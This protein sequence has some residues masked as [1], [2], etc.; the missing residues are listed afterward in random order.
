[1]DLKTLYSPEFIF[2]NSSIDKADI[3]DY[4][5]ILINLCNQLDLKNRLEDDN[6]RTT[7][8]KI[9]N[10]DPSNYTDWLRL[11]IVA[12]YLFL[13]HNW[14]GPAISFD[15]NIDWLVNNKNEEA[16]RELT[17]GDQCNDN[18]EYLELLYLSKIIF[19]NQKLQQ[20]LPTSL[21]WAIRSNYVHQ[22]ILDEES[23]VL[24]N[25]TELLIDKMSKL[26]DW[27]ND[28]YKSFETLFYIEALQFTLLYRRINDSEK[29][30]KQAQTIAKLTLELGG[31]QGK[32]TKYQEE[33]KPQLF[34]DIKT[35][36]EIFP[37]EVC[38][39]LPHS[40]H[41][42]DDL[43]LD[44]V[45]FSEEI[46][47]VELGSIEETVILAKCNHLQI[48]LPI[49]DFAMEETMPYLNTIINGTKNWAL[50][51]EALRQRSIFE[52][53][54]K[55]GIERALSQSES[56]VGQY[57]Q[58]KPSVFHRTNLLFASGMKPIWIFKQNLADAMLN[59]GLV[60]GALD[61]YLNLKLWEEV[62]VC[63]TILDLRHKAAEVIRQ[64]LSK[65]PT[66]KLW[67]LLGD[68][69]QDTSHYET[70]W[71]LSDRSSSRAQKHW[72]FYYF[73]RKRYS[74][75]IPHL[76]LSVKLNNIQE[77]VWIRLGFAALQSEKWELAA[78]AYRRY[79][80]LEQKNFEAWNNLA[81]VYIKLGN[82]PRAW[83]SLK[84]AVKC[85]FN[86]WQ[87]W[88]NLMV[89]SIDLGYF[90][91]VI[92]C[93]HRILDFKK[94]PH[95][96]YQVLRILTNAICNNINDNEGQPVKKNYDKALALFGRINASVPNDPE[97]L[98]LYAELTVVQNTDT[99]IKKATEYLQRAYRSFVVDSRWH[100]NISTA[101]N[102][103]Q[104]CSNLA[105]TYLR[106]CENTDDVKKKSMLGS[107]KLS[108]QSV[109]TKVKQENL[110]DYQDIMQAIGEL[111]SKWETINNEL[112]KINSSG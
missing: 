61:L 72:G 43:R 51:M 65:K 87:V 36:K 102:V 62:I 26:D 35:E 9:I 101:K 15:E 30:L 82:K 89:V 93:Y 22:M 27:N 85:D 103:L 92:E 17:L 44:S 33:E 52:M 99:A 29:Y 2:S 59:L 4:S 6:L 19:T 84:N 10:N 42:M 97:L 109:I 24:L 105:D 47:Q 5:N 68:A 12:L 54:D 56:L 16:Y 28:E 104:L 8:D 48:S 73:E 13:Q 78:H 38:P 76:E 106:C 77:N 49:D 58:S 95:I 60:K 50:K 40:V 81:K 20:I 31:A 71:E 67:C 107:A 1:M 34:L 80:E 75:A 66:V 37:F 39:D 21:W 74:E 110:T 3:S 111:E 53:K 11:G 100:Q 45:K 46:K 96:D 90:L 63:Y 14:T 79:C 7:I 69:E 23:D 98:Q 83:H 94:S 70:A 55:R 32:R 25:E 91:D 18:T 108:L 57:S 86:V 88:D 41:V 64:E 112:M